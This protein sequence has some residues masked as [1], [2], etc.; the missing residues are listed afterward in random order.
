M[1]LKMRE[2]AVAQPALRM[3]NVKYLILTGLQFLF[4]MFFGYFA[5]R[6]KSYNY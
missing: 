6:F 4:L 1:R 2:E 5:P 3:I